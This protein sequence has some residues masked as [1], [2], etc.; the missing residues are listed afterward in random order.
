MSL[1]RRVRV[2]LVNAF[3][4]IPGEAFRDQRYTFLYEM[5][6]SD[7][8]VRWLSSDFHHW[9]HRRRDRQMLPPEDQ[10]NVVLIKTLAYS[11]NVSLRRFISYLA[12]SLATIRHITQLPWRPDVIVCMGP[13]EQMFIVALYGRMRGV[14]VIID[15]IDTWPDLYLQAFPRKL[16]WLGQLVLAPYFLLSYCTF[17]WASHVS[18]VSKTY[19]SWAMARGRRTDTERFRCFP[20]GCRNQDFDSD[21]IRDARPPIRCLFAGQFGHSYDVEL[22]IEA[23]TRLAAAGRTDIEFILCGDGEKRAEMQRRAQN[24]ANVRLLGWLSPVQLNKLAADCHI[25]LC[26]YGAA[27]TQS[28]PTKIFDY[29]SM[30]LFVISSLPRE[31]E[32]LLESHEAGVSYGAGSVDSFLQSLDSVIAN[33]DLSCEARRR[34]RH[35]FDAHFASNIIYEEMIRDFIMPAASQG[36]GTSR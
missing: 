28:V 31:T 34:I 25:G 9:S 24:L 14:P 12:L 29:L 30:G 3:E 22:I 1:N 20:L 8:D 10:D 13:V 6:K 18:A 15:V 4:K 35:K 5:L 32:L 16:R 19:V 33:V 17:A 26:C 11:K 21:E 2:L 23:A 27:A 7:C 36:I